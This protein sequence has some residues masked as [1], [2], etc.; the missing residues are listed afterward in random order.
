MTDSIVTYRLHDEWKEIQ[1]KIFCRDIPK[2]VGERIL[3][4]EGP[5]EGPNPRTVLNIIIEK[6]PIGFSS[7]EEN[8]LKKVPLF[9]KNGEISRIDPTMNLCIP[10]IH[11]EVIL[12]W[13][14]TVPSLHKKAISDW[15]E[16]NK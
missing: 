13:Y 10:N 15:K 4:M 8:P 14:N 16:E 7:G 5:I 6:I 12:R 9:D 11:R 1:D 2:L 3:K